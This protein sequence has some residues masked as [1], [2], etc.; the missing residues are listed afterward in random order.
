MDKAYYQKNKEQINTRRRE[1]YHNDPA[2][3][4]KR[5]EETRIRKKKYPEKYKV[6]RRRYYL[7]HKEKFASRAK[8][9]VLDNPR[10]VKECRVQ[11]RAALKKKIYDHYG[12]VC[13][14]C[15]ESNVGFLTIDHVNNDGNKERKRVRGKMQQGGDRILLRIIRMNFPD[16]YQILCMNCN[17][18]KAQNNGICPHKS[19]WL[20]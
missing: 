13:K 9:W 18:G 8:K 1:R 6:W 14:C 2:Y 15:G 11:W 3:H 7:K 17:W 19:E 5:T 4:E 10:R 20:I 16:T 12:R